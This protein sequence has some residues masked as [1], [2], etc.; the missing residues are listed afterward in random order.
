MTKAYDMENLQHND[1]T[2]S[3]CTRLIKNGMSLEEAKAYIEKLKAKI[4]DLT[5][6]VEHYKMLAEERN[7]YIIVTEV[8]PYTNAI[9]EFYIDADSVKCSWRMIRK[10]RERLYKLQYD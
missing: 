8:D 7:K 1:C 4:D 10:L 5:R 2:Y 6:Q 3:E 9:D